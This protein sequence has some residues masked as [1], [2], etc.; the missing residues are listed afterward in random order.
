MVGW[1]LCLLSEPNFSR[2]VG[3]ILRIIRGRGFVVKDVRT[4]NWGDGGDKKI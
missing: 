1:N 2:Q 4:L 3:G